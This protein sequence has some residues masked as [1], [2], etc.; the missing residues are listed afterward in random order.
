VVCRRTLIALLVLLLTACAGGPPAPVLDRSSGYRTVS[1]QA[2]TPEVHLVQRGDTLYSI[3]FRYNLDHRTLAGWNAIGPPYTIYPEQVLWL[4]PPRQQQRSEVSPQVSKPAAAPANK[5]A[6]RASTPPA[7]S[8][9]GTRNS[10]QAAAGPAAK[11]DSAPSNNTTGTSGERLA[12]NLR[13]VWP[14][15]GGRLNREF[16]AGNKDRQGIDIAGMA[17]QPVVAAADGE[18]V[19]SGAG[20]VGYA[21]LIIIKHNDSLLSAYAHNRR[22]L[23][24]EGDRVTAGQQIAELGQSPRGADEVYVQIRRN[25]VPQNPMEYLPAR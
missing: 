13:W 2:G 24:A 16:V 5:P 25:G 7:N 17:G 18:V 1:N 6:A 12:A 3:A 21:G 8:G 23:V 20:F 9:S 19:Y 22:R 15:A 10:G 14:V 11:K 4:R